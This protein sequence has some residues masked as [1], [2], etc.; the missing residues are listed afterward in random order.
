MHT[1]FLMLIARFQ[2]AAPDLVRAFFDILGPK[3]GW[4][5]TV[6]GGGPSSALD[7]GAISVISYHTPGTDSDA[8]FRDVHP[9][10]KETCV[11]QF[12]QFCHIAYSE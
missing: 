8:L 6:V 10:Y 9:S 11:D 2:K 4:A 3:V 12:H 1:V 7:N 5:W